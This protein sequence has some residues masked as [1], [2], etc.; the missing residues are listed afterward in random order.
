MK[1]ILISFFLFLFMSLP[2]FSKTDNISV[3]YLKNKKHFAIMNPIAEI[4]AQKIIKKSLKKEINGDI[5]VKFDGYTVSSMKQGVFKYLEIN[6]K[7]SVIENVEI[8]RFIIK[9][10]SDFNQ[11]DITKKPAKIKTDSV[12][13]YE[14]E[15]NEKSLNQALNH[16][17]YFKTLNKINDLAYPLFVLYDVNVQIKNNM[18]Y[19]IMDYN[20]PISPSKKNKQFT[21]STDFKVENEEIKAKNIHIDSLYGNLQLNKVTNLINLLNPL[22]FTLSLLNEN[23]CKGKIENVKIEDNIIKINGK[24]FVKGEN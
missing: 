20:F 8:P 17:E 14:M 10:D 9:T 23:K 3:D 15:L 21:V 13:S 6:A 18:V 11:I 7:N 5:K 24:I 19:I 22:S 16:K 12:L 4:C 2:V 1:K